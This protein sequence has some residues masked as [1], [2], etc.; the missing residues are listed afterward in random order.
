MDISVGQGDGLDRVHEIV[1]RTG[2]AAEVEPAALAIEALAARRHPDDHRY[3]VI[4]PRE[5]LAARLR[6]RRAFDV[7]LA[8]VGLLALLISGAGIMNI[9]L[10]SVAERT[11]EIGVR[12]AVGARRREVLAQFAA[13][14][15]VLCVAG[16]V[17]GVPLGIAM[18]AVAASVAGWTIGVSWWAIA[19]ALLLACGVAVG[20]GTYPARLAARI[21]P[22]DAL[23]SG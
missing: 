12:R 3:E 23:R 10:A 11:R 7:V 19:L 22:I 6:A 5:L 21:D 9:M 4:V 16:A 18:A 2:G 1:V 8:A 17:A 15:L 20:F 14:A 13:E